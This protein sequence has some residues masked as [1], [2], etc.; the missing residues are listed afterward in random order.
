MVG[1]K[2]KNLLVMGTLRIS[3]LPMFLYTAMVTTGIMLYT[4]P[5]VLIC[6]ITGTWYLLPIFQF[7]L[8]L[9]STSSNHK[10]DL[11]S[12]EFGFFCLDSTHI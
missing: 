1:K 3:V 7:P 8:P 12:Y 10:S 2:E 9:P 6:H 4:T 5:L 11:F